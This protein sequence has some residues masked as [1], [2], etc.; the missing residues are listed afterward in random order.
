MGDFFTD[1]DEEEILNHVLKNPGTEDDI[2][3]GQEDFDPVSDLDK[4]L[5]ELHANSR[6]E[7]NNNEETI[8]EGES[9]LVEEFKEDFI[10]DFDIM[11]DNVDIFTSKPWVESEIEVWETEINGNKDTERED[12]EIIDN[13]QLKGKGEENTYMAV[14]DIIII[15]D[16]EVE[17]NEEEERSR[18]TVLNDDSKLKADEDLDIETNWDIDLEPNSDIDL[19]TDVDIEKRQDIQIETNREGGLGITDSKNGETDEGDVGMSEVN[20]DTERS[21]YE[22]NVTAFIVLNKDE[23][24]EVTE[25]VTNVSDI[26][27]EFG[28]ETKECGCKTD[29]DV[30]TETKKDESEELTKTDEKMNG[31]HKNLSLM[32]TVDISSSVSDS[33]NKMHIHLYLS[34]GKKNKSLIEIYEASIENGDTKN[35]LLETMR[36][37]YLTGRISM[38]EY[39][40]AIHLQI[41]ELNEV[42]GPLADNPQVKMIDSVHFDEVKDFMET[43]KDMPRMSSYEDEDVLQF[44]SLYCNSLDTD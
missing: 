16:I 4:F 30:D 27:K 44:L 33:L 12:K 23:F 43:D 26:N 8:M 29:I 1:T 14:S 11:K 39:F 20:E 6:E 22:T 5:K 35:K 13:I 36:S 40:E 24:E 17:L 9:G 18:E 21:G 37:H 28:I 32:Q 25:N 7:Q 31:E 19:E 34:K 42:D 41:G 15:K 10:E 38:R 2:P 3:S